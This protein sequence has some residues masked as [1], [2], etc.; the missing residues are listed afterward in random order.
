MKTTTRLTIPIVLLLPWFQAEATAVTPPAKA[1]ATPTRDSIPVFAAEVEMVTVDV[2]VVDKGGEVVPSLKKE[3]FLIRE[4]GAPQRIVRFESMQVPEAPAKKTAPPPVSSNIGI[5]SRPGRTFAVAF[6]DI[7]LDAFQGYRAKLAIAEFLRTGVREG[8]RVTLMATGG[9]TWWSAE[10]ESGRED[11]METLKQMNGR[12]ER[13]FNPRDYVSDYEALRVHIHNDTEVSAR[14]QRRFEETGAL[15]MEGIDSQERARYQALGMAHPYV[16]MRALEVYQESRVRSRITLNAL[17]RLLDSLSIVRGRKA[18]IL[19]SE[20]FVHDVL[21]DDFK[22]A[23]QSARKANVAIYFVDTKGLSGAITPLGDEFGA[24]NAS[25]FHGALYADQ[26]RAEEGAEFL[27]SETGGFSLKST[28]A[29]SRGILRIANEARCFYLLGYTPT[30]TARDGRYR[31]IDVKVNRRG[32]VVRARRGYYAPLEGG[33]APPAPD[34]ETDPEMRRALDAPF[35]IDGIPLRMSARVFEEKLRGRAR[36][37]LAAEAD[38]RE[39]EFRNEGGRFVTVLDMIMFVLHRQ[40]GELYQYPQKITMRLK[41]ETHAQALWYP[42]FREFELP[43]GTYQA[44]LVVR[45]ENSGRVSSVIH[46]FKVPDLDSWRVSSPIIADALADASGSRRVVIR[47]HRTFSRQGSLYCQF[48]VYGA[49]RDSATGLSS[50]SQGYKVV[51]TD[52][53]LERFVQPSRIVSSPNGAI[54]RLFG[55]PLEGFQPGD[56]EIV[57][58]VLDELRGQIKELREPFTVVEEP[59]DAS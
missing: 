56:Y 34:D 20:G 31:K 42:I 26:T 45:D 5:D 24:P 50:V 18:L 21:L 38:V 43:A 58:T 48:E 44:R 53:K 11:L 47:P 36:V 1:R 27:A 7:Q 13:D 2:V 9:G 29:L 25:Q 14:L 4:D 59:P 32:V 10:M 6:D 46:D 57:L 22:Q 12:R 28:D 15:Q 8:D 41:P 17:K 33:P 49:A 37:V 51:R 3:D 30:N 19:V 35:D 16:D 23:I 55:F 39:I 40:S 52:G 54:S